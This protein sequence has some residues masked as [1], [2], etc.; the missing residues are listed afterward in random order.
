MQLKTCQMFENVKNMWKELCWAN[1][2]RFELHVTS[3]DPS[4]M[5]SFTYFYSSI[6]DSELTEL[7]FNLLS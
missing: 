3:V 6:H 1:V 4:G 7:T 2:E 5:W